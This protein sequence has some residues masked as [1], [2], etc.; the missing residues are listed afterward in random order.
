MD[1][2]LAQHLIYAQQK[3]NCLLEL[4]AKAGWNRNP[5]AVLKSIKAHNLEEEMQDMMM[6]D[7]L[8]DDSIEDLCDLEL[9]LDDSSSV[10]S[11]MTPEYNEERWS[12]TNYLRNGYQVLDRNNWTIFFFRRQ[13]RAGDFIWFRVW[14]NGD[15]GSGDFMDREDTEILDFVQRALE[16]NPFL[17][18]HVRTSLRG[19]RDA[20]FEAEHIERALR[21]ILERAQAQKIIAI[22]TIDEL[23]REQ[24]M[25][26]KHEKKGKPG[27][28]G[29]LL[30]GAINRLTGNRYSLS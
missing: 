24:W 16:R 2:F 8:D 17:C 29:F 20:V 4:E 15:L 18:F 1:S 7:P 19:H 26:V 3:H 12:R 6:D 30:S 14:C 5:I 25:E 28:W 10:S 27:Y 21:M 22:P 9:S 11:D 23:K 13:R